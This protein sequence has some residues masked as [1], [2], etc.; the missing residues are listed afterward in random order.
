M[1]G[2][3]FRIFVNI[4]DESPVQV[5]P[6]GVSDEDFKEGGI[7]LTS[8]RTRA[9]FDGVTMKPIPDLPTEEKEEESPGA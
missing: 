1:V 8:F 4:P 7:A 2:P 5:F 9:A 3:A 6:D